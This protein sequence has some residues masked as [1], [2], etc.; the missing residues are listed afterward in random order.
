MRGFFDCHRLQFL[1][2]HRYEHLFG[3][4]LWQ[5]PWLKNRFQPWLYSGLAWKQ[6][7]GHP[8][9]ILVM[10]QSLA[11]NRILPLVGL[12][13]FPWLVSNFSLVAHF[14]E[15]IEELELASFDYRLPP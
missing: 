12:L 3:Q 4:R 1:C 5:F 11:F 15:Q 7:R 13:E 9:F 6:P 10:E 2:E 8:L 14:A